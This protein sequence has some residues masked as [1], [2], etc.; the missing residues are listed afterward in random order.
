MS[1]YWPA[2]GE[3]EMTA[4]RPTAH[5][6]VVPLTLA[7][8]LHVWQIDDP[9]GTPAYVD[10]TAAFNGGGSCNPWPASEAIGDQMA[11]AFS[12][13]V[14]RLRIDMSATLGIGGTLKIKYW[15]GTALAEVAN[16]TDGTTGF[17]VAGVNEITFDMPAAVAQTVNGEGPYYWLY[18][19]VLTTYSTNPV[20]DEGWILHATPIPIPAINNT[21]SQGSLRFYMN[22]TDAAADAYF[23]VP[24]TDDV[25]GRDIASSGGTLNVED[26]DH[27][28]AAAS[29]PELYTEDTAPD[30]VLVCIDVA[31]SA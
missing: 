19:E 27:A 11:V 26:I 9:G 20:L 3:D 24:G 8:A 6:S 22:N 5:E 13:P 23:C 7:D 30:P 17:T 29:P 14:R 10:I 28:G 2:K 21:G 31:G 18:F 4:Y 16:L 25:T 12:R 1:K 15:N